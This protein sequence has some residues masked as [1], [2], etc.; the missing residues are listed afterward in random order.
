MVLVL[1]CPTDTKIK[2]EKTMQAFIRLMTGVETKRFPN[3]RQ[4][5]LRESKEKKE[6]MLDGEPYRYKPIDADIFFASGR[7]TSLYDIC[8]IEVV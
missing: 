2:K 1:Y 5:I 4:I 7:T 3:V 8:D 6:T